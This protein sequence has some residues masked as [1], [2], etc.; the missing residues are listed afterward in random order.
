MVGRS[1]RARHSWQAEL[2]RQH[3]AAM[4]PDLGP[5]DRAFV[6]GLHKAI[7]HRQHDGDT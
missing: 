5:I 2:L 7:A 3:G 4:V 1:K 6:L